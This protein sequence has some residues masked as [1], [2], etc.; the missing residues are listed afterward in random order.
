METWSKLEPFFIFLSI[1]LGF[2]FSK[3]TFISNLCG[4]LEEYLFISL[5]FFIFLEIDWANLKEAFFNYKFLSFDLIINFLWTPIFAF[6]LGLLLFYNNIYLRIALVLLLILPCTD[7]YLI[8]TEMTG[9]NVELSTSILPYNLIIQLLIL[10]VC[11]FIFFGNSNTSLDFSIASESIFE[12]LFPLVLALIIH[13]FLKNSETLEHKVHQYCDKV[14]FILVSIIAFS[15]FASEGTE[16]IESLT[17][18]PLFILAVIIFYVI[19]F[20]ISYNLAKFNRFSFQDLISLVFTT[21]SRNTPLSLTL[22]GLLFPQ[23]RIIS[24]VLL[25]GPITEIPFSLIISLLLNKLTKIQNFPHLR[26][27]K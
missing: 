14:E 15:I 27:I 11:L 18:F 21:T 5:L 19:N 2:L 3:I 24:I 26:H 7:W 1:I 4:Y 25:I 23:Y 22:S 12:L 8:F 16:L 13:F 10:P 9:G 17:S 6:L 20:L